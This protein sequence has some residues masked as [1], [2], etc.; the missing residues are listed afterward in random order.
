MIFKRILQEELDK[1]IFDFVIG[2]EKSRN[3]VK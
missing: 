3:L 1:L 2:T